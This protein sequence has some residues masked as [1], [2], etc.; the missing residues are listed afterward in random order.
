MEGS[1]GIAGMAFLKGGVVLVD[2][3]ELPDSRRVFPERITKK[4]RCNG[5]TA[6]PLLEVR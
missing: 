4:L 2:R 5:L 3:F 1:G 6:Q